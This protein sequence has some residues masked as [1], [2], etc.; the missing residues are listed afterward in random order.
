LY[1]ANLDLQKA[2]ETLKGALQLQPKSEET[3]GRLA[4]VFAALDGQSDIVPG[5]RAAKIISDVT[6]RN[7]HAGEFFMALGDSMDKLRRYPAAARFYEEAVRCMPRHAYARGQWGLMLMR[8]GEEPQAKKLLDESFDGP[9]FK[10]EVY[11]MITNG[12]CALDG[13]EASLAVPEPGANVPIAVLTQYEAVH[14][15]VDRAA[16]EEGGLRRR[17]GG[18]VELQRIA[19]RVLERQPLLV[20]LGARVRRG[21]ADVFAELILEHFEALCGALDHAMWDDLVFAWIVVRSVASNAFM[22]HR[23][24]ATYCLL[25]K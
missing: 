6:A 5:S 13:T 24:I 1:L 19:S 2:V 10:D 22:Y 14:L 4:A 17:I 21:D 18:P 11:L 20:V 12:L 8:L 9:E 25:M 15:F 16:A 7:P 3:L 23:C